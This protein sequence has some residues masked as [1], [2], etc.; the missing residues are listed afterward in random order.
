MLV[1]VAAFTAFA[2]I[3][4][5]AAT[6]LALLVGLII[7]GRRQ[8][9]ARLVQRC[10]VQRHGFGVQVGG[11]IQR[12]ALVVAALWTLATL[13]VAAATALSTAFTSTL[14]TAFTA[15]FAA[16]FTSFATTG[17]AFAL[18]ACVLRRILGWPVLAL[19]RFAAHGCGH[20]RLI[21]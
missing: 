15:A 13:V 1:A 16:T 8:S 20:G 3:A 12:R 4:I 19:R 17:L 5:A 7:L 10:C 21:C 2:A 6:R 14:A 18:T 11:G 9:V